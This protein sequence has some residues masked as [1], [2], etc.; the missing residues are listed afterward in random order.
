LRNQTSVNYN[1]TGP[2]TSGNLNI[3]VIAALTDDKKILMTNEEKAKAC[4]TI[5]VTELIEKLKT[6]N[7]L[8]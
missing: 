8:V 2:I 3:A 7:N 1:E 4:E 5:G 6:D